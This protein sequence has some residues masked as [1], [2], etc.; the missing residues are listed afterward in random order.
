[1]RS[2]KRVAVAVD[3]GVCPFLRLPLELP[4]STPKLGQFFTS[5]EQKTP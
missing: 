2:R 3:Q 5:L 4:V 1:M